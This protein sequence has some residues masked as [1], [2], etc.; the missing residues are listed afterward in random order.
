MENKTLAQELEN[1]SAALKDLI[2]KA[3]Q[4]YEAKTG[5]VITNITPVRNVVL[6]RPTLTR[7][8]LAI[9]SK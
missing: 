9:G 3:V 5:L 8:E 7:I 2:F 4:D 6:N 1:E